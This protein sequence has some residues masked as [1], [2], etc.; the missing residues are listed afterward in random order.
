MRVE[1]N[2]DGLI[3]PTHNYAGLALGNLASLA[4][5]GIHAHP[6]NAALQGLLK[7][8]TLMDLGI[9]QGVFPPQARPLIRFLKQL[10]FSGSLEQ[11]LRRAVAEAPRLFAASYSASS[12]WVANAATVSA[13]ADTFD[14][15]VHFTPANL[16]SHVHRS[17]ETAFTGQVLQRIFQAEQ[18]FVHHP[19]LPHHA[20][21]GDEGA[22][23][24]TRFISAEGSSG[25]GLFVFGQGDTP[26]YA[27][28][29]QFPARQSLE[30]SRSII[31]QHGLSPDRVLCV[32][33][34][35][36]SIDQ[37]VFHND[38]I[39]VGHESFFLV[40]EQAFVDQPSVLAALKKCCTEQGGFDLE[41]FE[42]SQQELS[43]ADAVASYV[44]NS[45]IVRVPGGMVLIAPQECQD[46]AAASA[47]IARILAGENP[48]TAV[49][50][51]DCRESMHNGGGPACLRLRV[52][53]THEEQ[54][55]ILPGVILTPDLYLRLVDWVNRYYRDTLKP[56][57]FLDPHWVHETHEA[58][59][60][61]TQ[62]LGLG[63]IYD[64]QQ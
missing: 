37:G 25:I 27:V 57:D 56:E 12:M 5:R 20:A 18:H 49:H 34:A 47:V 31:R 9:P 17:L 61:L 38:V 15:K 23:N 43:V 42:V 58:L 19:A 8:K 63:T 36:Q 35:P 60:Q 26:D 50:Y 53:V 11:I 64:F 52:W 24:H 40:H 13:S 10:G 46:N 30:A 16:A 21:L 39:S 1:I 59:D 14:Q 32:Q 28:P 4:H 44:F 3:G 51:V 29:H 7:M 2:F 22:A 55:N 33:Q 48:I 6:R 45:Q 62:L 41:V 54:V